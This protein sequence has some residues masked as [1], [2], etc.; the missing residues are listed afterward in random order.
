VPLFWLIEKGHVGHAAITDLDAASFA[1]EQRSDLGRW[2]GAASADDL[3]V[4]VGGWRTVR[5][6]D[7]VSHAVRFTVAGRELDLV[8]SP[9][10]P[11]ALHGEPPGIQSM[12]P[13]GISHYV[14]YTRMQVTGTLRAACGWFGCSEVAVTGSAWHDHQWGDFRVDRMAGWDWFA[15]QL[16]DGA[17]LMVYLLWG[18][19]G[20]YLEA[21]GSYVTERGTVVPLS[22]SGF[23]VRPTGATWASP[24]TGAVYPAGW[25]VVVPA[26]HLDVMVTPLVDDQEMDTRATTGIVYWEGAVGVTGSHVGR[27]YVELT[28]YD[29]LPFGQGGAIPVHDPAGLVGLP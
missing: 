14:S 26:F 6:D 29:R 21:A 1:M 18:P 12:G 24:R 19:D 16:A 15:L 10:K 11:V 22:G 27:G 23:A 9:G 2:L 13:G 5:A 20:G 25:R 4:A 7:G 28:N 17:D 3:D 8:L